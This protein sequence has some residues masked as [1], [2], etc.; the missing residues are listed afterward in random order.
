MSNNYI[1]YQDGD[2]SYKVWTLTLPQGTVTKKEE[3]TVRITSVANG[4]AG[5]RA[6]KYSSTLR[7]TF[8]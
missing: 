4:L 8:K 6:G 5:G 3:C 1:F 2:W 7:I